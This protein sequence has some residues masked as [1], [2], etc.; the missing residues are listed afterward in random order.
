MIAA[1]WPADVRV[2]QHNH[3]VVQIDDFLAVEEVKSLLVTGRRQLGPRQD[4]GSVDAKTRGQARQDAFAR[5]LDATAMDD[6]VVDIVRARIA[7]ALRL[8][9][10]TI[11]F[12]FVEDSTPASSARAA[13]RLEYRYTHVLHDGHEQLEEGMHT[14]VFS[15]A[16]FLT[17]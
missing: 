7:Q 17:G 6:P 3:N 2:L 5:P 16:I 15:F 11:A 8:V 12:D 10:S 13:E 4:D 1:G 9:N 14:P